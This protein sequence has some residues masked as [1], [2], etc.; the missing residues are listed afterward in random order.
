MAIDRFSK[1]EFEAALPKDG[2]GKPMWSCLGLVDNEYNYEIEVR[3]TNKRIVIRSSI[4]S[5]GVAADTGEDSIRHWVEYYYKNEWRPLKKH[6]SRWTARTKN[7]RT[8]LTGKLRDLYKLALDDSNGKPK[9]VEVTIVDGFDKHGVDPEALVEDDSDERI[10]EWRKHKNEF[11]K[12]EALQEED[13]FKAKME[14][15]KADLAGLDE[16]AKYNKAMSVQTTVDCPVCG[17]EMIKRHRR[18]DNAPFWGCSTFPKCRGT[19]PFVSADEVNAKPKEFKPTPEQVAIFDAVKDQNGTDIVV[20]ALAGTGKTTTI[21]MALKYARGKVLFC[22]FNKR[23]ADELRKR[24]PRHV[25]C[26]TLHS[27]GFQ[28]LNKALPTKPVV[29]NNKKR[30]IAKEL[31]PEDDDETRHARSVLVKVASLVQATLTDAA[32]RVAVMELINRYGIDTSGINGRDA[33]T[34]GGEVE[35]HYT[36]NVEETVLEMLPRMLSICQVRTTVIDYDDMIWLPIVL[37][38]PIEKY[39]WVFVDEAQDLNKSQLE[40]VHSLVNETGRVCCVGDR[41]Q[42]IYGFRGADV[43]AIPRLIRELNDVKVLPLTVSWR[44]PFSVVGLA[45][46]MVPQFQAAPD[47]PEGE[48]EEFVS[49]YKLMQQVQDN[50]MILCRINAPLVKVCY[51]L[52]KQGKKATI[53]GRDIGKG[54]IALIDRLKPWDINDL[55]VKLNDYKF[56]EIDKLTAAGRESQAEA[57]KDKCDTLVALTGENL[58]RPDQW[59]QPEFSASG[60]R[61]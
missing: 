4:D 61:S 28:T 13:A 2:S 47:A 20:E 10:D 8:N 25:N 27:V 34:Y 7:W 9:Q 60:Q 26:A 57:I 50:D 51:S 59:H 41:H 36:H 48:I 39:N 56:K 11:A 22:A 3:G 43:D 5:T 24:A 38:L 35:V 6:H 42:S 54:L 15:D 55:L 52:I 44:C 30:N 17:S 16:V 23:I 14:R 40:L 31:L 53:V 49:E 18:S 29:D 32:D 46:Q 37:R 19:R 45:Q 1:E 12:I 21:V 58:H 33:T